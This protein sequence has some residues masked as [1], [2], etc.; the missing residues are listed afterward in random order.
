MTNLALNKFDKYVVG[1][2]CIILSISI[3]GFLSIFLVV[4]LIE[5]LDRFLDNNVPTNIVFR[6]YFEEKCLLAYP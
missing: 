3:F 6:Y 4:D 1:Q 2:F 5:N